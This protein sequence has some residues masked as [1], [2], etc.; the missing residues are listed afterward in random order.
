MYF[1][2]LNSCKDCLPAIKTWMG[3]FK[4]FNVSYDPNAPRSQNDFFP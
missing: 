4:D 3:A 2:I 1:T